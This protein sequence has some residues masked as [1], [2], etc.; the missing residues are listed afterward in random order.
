MVIGLTG[1][2]GSGKSTVAHLLK[3]MGFFVV[4]ADQIAREVVLPGTPALLKISETFGSGVLKEDGTLNRHMLGSLV[5]SNPEL[6]QKL[7]DITHPAI[8]REIKCLV[9]DCHTPVV[10]DAPLL[11][12]TG[13]T[14]LCQ[15]V[16][17]V[18]ASDPVRCARI[19]KRD[20]ISP[21]EAKKRLKAQQKQKSYQSQADYVVN[22]DTNMEDLKQQVHKIVWEI[23]GRN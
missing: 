11:F 16:I 4:D 12:E 19:V 20:G 5:F 3:E 10:I 17:V 9:A 21:S 13:L 1:L 6:L 14:S 18:T 15:K 8:L 7:N 23:L 22:N 2:S